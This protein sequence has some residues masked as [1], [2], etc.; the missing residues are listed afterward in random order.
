MMNRILIFLAMCWAGLLQAQDTII[1]SA[2]KPITVGYYPFMHFSG[3]LK[4]GI[5]LPLKGNGRVQLSPLIYNGLDTYYD[6]HVPENVTVTE[7]EN[8]EQ[9]LSGFGFE[10]AYLYSPKDWMYDDAV[11]YVGVGVGVHSIKFNY[12]NYVYYNAPEDGLDYYR[13][14]FVETADRL[15]RTDMFAV[16]GVRTP[17]D[18]FIGLDVNLGIAYKNTAVTNLDNFRP[19]DDYGAMVPSHG[20]NGFYFRFQ[21]AVTANFAKKDKRFKDL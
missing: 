14:G 13:Y 4:L 3:A 17:G 21:M 6:T 11:T 20:G 12:G 19:R 8:F 9:R 18:L 7:H 1:M 10:A 2:D 15:F 5:D 16:V